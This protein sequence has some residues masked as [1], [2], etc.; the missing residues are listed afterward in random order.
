LGRAVVGADN[1]GARLDRFLSLDLMPSK[2]SARKA[3]KRGDVLL[4]GAT[5]ES[6]RIVRQGDQVVLLASTKGPHKV[7]E[8][9]VP[10]VYEDAWMAVVDKPAGLATSGSKH[11][12]LEHALPFNLSPST[13][14]HALAAPRVVH[15]LDFGTSGLVAVA[16][17]GAAHGALGRAFETRQVDKRYLAVAVGALR[18]EGVCEEPIEGRRAKTGWRTLEIWSSQR[19]GHLS[20]VEARPET[21]RTHQIRR[22]L[23]HLGHPI[24]GDEVYG[25][26]VGIGRGLLLCAVGLALPHPDTG[27]RLDLERDPPPKFLRLRR[28]EA[29]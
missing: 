17:T 5:V 27:E 3:A 28:P 29:P 8:L 12:T 13:L 15:R 2:A 7:L 18:G 4:N 22:H 11:R 6:S 24:V 25:H 16:K 19:F 9:R 21:G 10:V 20:L 1:D 14:P 23:A 26:D